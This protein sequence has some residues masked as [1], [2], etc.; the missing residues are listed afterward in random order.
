MI[1]VF[2]T[3]R[4]SIARSRSAFVKLSMRAAS[5]MNGAG[6]NW[7][8]SGVRRRIASAGGTFHRSIRPWR[9]ASA[10]VS[11]WR[12]RTRKG[13]E[14][15]LRAMALAFTLPD[16]DGN[17]TPLHVDG[18]PAAVVV[19]TCN[20]CPYALAWHERLQ[21]VAR[22]YAD[23]GVRFL[24]I[25]SNDAARYPRDAPDAMRD[26]VAA[27]EFATPVPVRRVAGGRPRVGRQDDAARVR[28]R[29]FRGRVQRRAGLRLRRPDANAEWLRAALDDVLA[30]R[31]VAKPETKPVGCSIKW[32]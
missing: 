27:G 3:V 9:A 29:R 11:S 25:S 23:R 5:P 8:C 7:A 24:Q 12:V 1:V 32:R 21:A 20:H 26:R 16:T 18:A 22:D 28:H 15:T 17:P 6:A 19:F 31:P 14:R 10:T 30:G 13:R 4:A 2:T